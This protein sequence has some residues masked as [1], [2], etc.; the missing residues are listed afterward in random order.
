MSGTTNVA[1]GKTAWR[2]CMDAR[3]MLLEEV[4]KENSVRTAM[5]VVD[6]DQNT[7]KRIA[8][9]NAQ[10]SKLCLTVSW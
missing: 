5:L 4:L 7:L 3:K 1:F 2:L 10:Q 9:S 6:E 8:L